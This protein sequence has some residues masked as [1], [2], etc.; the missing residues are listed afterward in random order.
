MGEGDI[1]QQ[2]NTQPTPLKPQESTE[3][4][5]VRQLNEE[6]APALADA[7]QKQRDDRAKNL[8]LIT[9]SEPNKPI[10]VGKTR[11]GATIYR[12]S[13]VAAVDTPEP[14]DRRRANQTQ[15]PEEYVAFFRQPFEG[16]R[17]EL[18]P[19]DGIAVPDAHSPS[20]YTVYLSRD[21]HNQIRDWYL[22]TIN[23][24][25]DDRLIEF[26]VKRIAEKQPPKGKNPHVAL[27][28]E[29]QRG[30]SRDQSGFMHPA[31]M[32]T[33]LRTIKPSYFVFQNDSTTPFTANPYIA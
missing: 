27:Y 26:K 24:P 25:L 1:A 22:G 4:R 32:E 29:L 14:Y 31:A 7:I 23:S 3:E 11:L 6:V 19:W 8:A 16:G 30:G 9:P 13:I 15:N 33:I 12:N 17:E 18:G 28:A 5:L 2:G 20:G 10:A 21:P